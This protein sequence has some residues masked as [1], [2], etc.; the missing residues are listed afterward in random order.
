LANFHTILSLIL[1]PKHLISIGTGDFLQ[2]KT[3]QGVHAFAP[4]ETFEKCSI[5]VK[6]NEADNFNRRN[7]LNISRIKI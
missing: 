4:D 5:L 7:I 6:V 2:I 1:H 3:S